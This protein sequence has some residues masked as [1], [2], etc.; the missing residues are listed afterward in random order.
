MLVFCLR[1]VCTGVVYNLWLPPYCVISLK[2][3]GHFPLIFVILHLDRHCI[4]FIKGLC[5]FWTTWM[6]SVWV[7]NSMGV[8]TM[9]LLVLSIAVKPCRDDS[10]LGNIKHIFASSVMS[11]HWNVA[12]SWHT[13]PWKTTL[14]ARF[15]GQTWGP[16]G[17]DRTHL[18]PMLARW[19]LLLGKY[20]FIMHGVPDSKVH[21]ANMGPIFAIW[22]PCSLRR[23]DISSLGI[24]PV[25]S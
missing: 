5:I 17:A 4:F 13:S 11:K 15:M 8:T 7:T 21:G 18:G 12:G 22:G 1:Q 24:N 14:I 2:G 10:I 20:S 6:T 25:H 3:W 23:Q 16:S 19:T 9:I